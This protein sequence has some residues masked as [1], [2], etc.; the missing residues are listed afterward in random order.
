MRTATQ[1]FPAGAWPSGE[2]LATVTLSYAERCRRRI[3]M[4][5]DA[6]APFLLNL[7]RPVRLAQGD[8]LRLDQGGFLKVAAG[9]EPLLE[10][11]ATDSAHLAR[12]AWHVGNRHAPA[13]IEKNRI[14]I[15]RDRVVRDMLLGLGATVAE[16]IEAFSPEP[17]AYAHDHGKIVIFFL[18][19]KCFF[20]CKMMLEIL[21]HLI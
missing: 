14:L 10:A 13:Q 15:G 2:V 21:E 5:D 6:G 11:K 9:V 4:T 1:W 7:P 16:K 17:G 8:G 3:Q 19:K 20:F 18:Y 12:L